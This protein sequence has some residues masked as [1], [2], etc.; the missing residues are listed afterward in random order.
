MH[1]R[2]EALFWLLIN[3][4]EQADL[5]QT[6]TDHIINKHIINKLSI[7]ESFGADHQLHTSYPQLP[8]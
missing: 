1:S 2:S 6:C 8:S 3:F 4:T 5:A 7:I